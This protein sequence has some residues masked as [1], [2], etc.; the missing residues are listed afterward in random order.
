MEV[1]VW[2][3]RSKAAHTPWGQAVQEAETATA[4]K[5]GRIG[6]WWQ[7]RS[8]TRGLSKSSPAK[9]S[10]KEHK[11]HQKRALPLVLSLNK[12]PKPRGRQNEVKVVEPARKLQILDVLRSA[13]TLMSQLSSAG[14]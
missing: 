4:L 13:Q 3:S 14:L 10:S 7:I 6:W 12:S 8:A 1:P 5:K 11:T 2:R 9:H